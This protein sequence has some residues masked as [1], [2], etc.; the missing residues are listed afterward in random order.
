MLFDAELAHGLFV[1]LLTVL[2]FF[3][4]FIVIECFARW[5]GRLYRWIFNGEGVSLGKALC[6][7][8]WIFLVILSF[9]G[10][11]I[12]GLAVANI[13]RRPGRPR[14]HY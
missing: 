13:V 1:M 6:F 10:L 8:F 14:K 9:F 7:P 11:V 4:V 2:G 5:K 12:G 3:G